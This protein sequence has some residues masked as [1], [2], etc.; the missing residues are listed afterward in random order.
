MV[1]PV[2]SRRKVVERISC[3]TKGVC[4]IW[5]C[6]SKLPSEKVSSTERRKL[7]S[8]HTVKYS[9]GTWHHITNRGK[10]G[11]IARS[12][13]KVCSQ[14]RQKNFPERKFELDEVK[15]KNRMIE[16]QRNKKKSEA[17]EEAEKTLK[18]KIK[19]DDNTPGHACRSI[20]WKD[21]RRT[22]IY[23]WVGQRS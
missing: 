2:K 20:T 6:V 22:R 19:N 12:Y 14:I 16:N 5:L 17:Q 18:K 23:L 1:S 15:Q 10:K 7:G 21:L 9:K 13:S 8:N 4:T 3:L 11:S